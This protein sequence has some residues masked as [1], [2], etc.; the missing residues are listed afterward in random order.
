M[1]DSDLY[2]SATE[3]LAFCEPLIGRHAVIIFDEWN[4]YKLADNNQGERR[5]F[6]EFLARNP[7]LKAEPLPSYHRSS[8]IFLLTRQD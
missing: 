7:D 1:V 8:A 3:A 4:S 2:S 6:E 5:A